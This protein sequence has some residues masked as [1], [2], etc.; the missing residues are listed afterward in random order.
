MFLCEAGSGAEEGARRNGDGEGVGRGGEG[1]KS[2]VVR[3][4]RD[5]DE[6]Q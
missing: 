6:E 3:G 1:K 4:A 2:V 5:K